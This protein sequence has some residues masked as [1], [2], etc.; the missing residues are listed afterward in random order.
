MYV[1]FFADPNSQ[2]FTHRIDLVSMTPKMQQ[3]SSFYLTLDMFLT[4]NPSKVAQSTCKYL[5]IYL[6]NRFNKPIGLVF[7]QKNENVFSFIA[8]A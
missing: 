5:V 7:V 2:F 8:F 6:C 1:L 4:G 3:N